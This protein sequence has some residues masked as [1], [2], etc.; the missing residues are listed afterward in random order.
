MST[1]EAIKE[2]NKH[3]HRIVRAPLNS[4]WACLFSFQCRQLYVPFQ[5]V[6]VYWM[7]VKPRRTRL[8]NTYSAYGGIC[9]RE[10]CDCWERNSIH[11]G[12]MIGIAV[13]IAYRIFD[14]ATNLEDTTWVACSGLETTV[15]FSW[16]LSRIEV[17]VSFSKGSS[18]LK[19]NRH[20]TFLIRI[21]DDNAPNL[22]KDPWETDVRRFAVSLVIVEDKIYVPNLDWWSV[23]YKV[24]LSISKHQ[25]K[26]CLQWLKFIP[27]VACSRLT[28][29]SLFSD[30]SALSFLPTETFFFSIQNDRKIWTP[31]SSMT[32][33]IHMINPI[34]IWLLSGIWKSKWLNLE[35]GKWS[36]AVSHC[37]WG[38]VPIA[39]SRHGTFNSVYLTQRK[40]SKCK[41]FLL[42]S[43]YAF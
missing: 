19:Q 22:I 21:R 28:L 38:V 32:S 20:D 2:E 43:S 29:L 3:R 8:S 30:I 12:F 17:K 1:K 35:L 11:D 26:Q 23:I 13:A 40:V 31:S 34:Q 41:E 15:N 9:I 4:L 25:V 6:N 36:G 7:L 5:S 33:I 24:S 16:R 14:V 10:V 42:L 18:R 39:S 37:K 27:I